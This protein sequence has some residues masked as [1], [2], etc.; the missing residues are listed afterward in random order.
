MTT[1]K[2]GW[3]EREKMMVALRGEARVGLDTPLG[4][5]APSGGTKSRK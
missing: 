4:E 3:P 5:H 2:G 1:N